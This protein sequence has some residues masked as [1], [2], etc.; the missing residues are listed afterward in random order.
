MRP[1]LFMSGE[2]RV[3]QHAVFLKDN[4]GHTMSARRLIRDVM[5]IRRNGIVESIHG[6]VYYARADD[7][8]VE[9]H[10][11]DF[12]ISEGAPC[13][14]NPLTLRRMSDRHSVLAECVRAGL[15][16][17][18]VVQG[19]TTDKPRLPFPFVLKTGQEHRG[20][21]KHLCRSESDV[22][23]WDGIATVEPFFDGVST[24]VLLIGERAFGIEFSNP[25]SW[26][27]NQV[28][29]DVAVWTI[30]PVI[31]AH[32]RSIR[33]LFGLEIAGMDYVVNSDGFHFLEINQYPGVDFSDETATAARDVFNSW[34][35][36]VEKLAS[37][38]P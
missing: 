8:R 3:S 16:D 6:F 11:L 21:G 17:H 31:E 25:D 27:K 14:P 7:V 1:F 33:A 13:I 20:E 32:A 35:D 34:M 10:N 15:V 19:L 5:G 37:K 26:V 12:I 22:P 18:P 2:F 4:W 36:M 28:G 38:L 23:E 29:A 9:H 24:R 30:P